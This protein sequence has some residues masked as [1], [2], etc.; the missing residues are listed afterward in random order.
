MWNACEV[1]VRRRGITRAQQSRHVCA[2]PSSLSLS[3]SLRRAVDNHLPGTI[4]CTNARVSCPSRLALPP[5]R[6]PKI[7]WITDGMTCHV[8]VGEDAAAAALSSAA[9]QQQQQQQQQQ[10]LAPSTVSSH[11]AID[12]APPR[13][14][15]AVQRLA[16]GVVAKSVFAAGGAAAEMASRVYE[17]SIASYGGPGSGREVG[18]SEQYEL[19]FQLEGTQNW[20]RYTLWVSCVR[21]QQPDGVVHGSRAGALTRCCNTHVVALLLLR[22]VVHALSRVPAFAGGDPAL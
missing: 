17:S 2:P 21:A 8:S 3:P 15:T 18:P 13:T 19:V 12:S 14:R 7:S 10:L 6:P 11:S 4:E 22:V 9:Q 5:A 1:F 20:V 16:T